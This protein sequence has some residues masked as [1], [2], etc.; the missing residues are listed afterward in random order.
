MI[1]RQTAY[2]FSLTLY[3]DWQRLRPLL[4][5][6]PKLYFHSIFLPKKVTCIG[7]GNKESGIRAE[8]VALDNNKNLLKVEDGFLRSLG[9]GINQSLSVSILI[10]D[11]GIYYDATRPSRLENI[12]NNHQFSSSCLTQAQNVLQTLQTHKL[13]KYNHT[14]EPPSIVFPLKHAVKR[15]LVVDQTKGDAS[16]RDGLGSEK[17]FQCM[18]QAAIQENP[19]TEIW[20]KSHPDV[21]TG[22][23]QGYFDY[24][25]LK[26]SHP[27]LNWL[28]ESWNI[29]SILAYFE[30]VYV[31]T[32]QLGFDALIAG[33]AVTCF[34]VPFYAGWGLTDD[35]QP[36]QRRLRKRTL[37]E[38][39]AAAY[40]EYALYLNPETG[41]QGDFFQAAQFIIRQ[42]YYAH[43]WHNNGVFMQTQDVKTMWSGRIFCFGFRYWKHAHVRPFFGEG[44]K[45]L[46]VNSVTE[47][48]SHGISSLD[49]IA[50]WGQKAIYGLESLAQN[51]QLPITRVEDGFLRSVGLGADFVRPKSLVFDQSG[52]YFDPSTPSD[53]ENILN[54]SVFDESLLQRAHNIRETVCRERLTKY[55]IDYQP[56]AIELP[57]NQKI[58]L[59]PGQVEDDASI[60]KGAAAIKTNLDLLKAA[61]HA[62][63]KAFIIYKPHPDVLARNRQGHVETELLKSLCDHIESQASVID[64][65]EKC[66]EIHTITSLTG[67]DALLRNKRV[68]TY[69][70]PFYAGWG[71]TEDHVE[72][73][74]RQRQLQLDELVAGALILYPRY[75]DAKANGFVECETIIER[76][77]TERAKKQQQRSLLPKSWQRQI[78]KWSSFLQGS[79]EGWLVRRQAKS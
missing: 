57:L 26:Q 73:P 28:T 10:D 25:Q 60:L 11:I 61:R 34:G 5:C 49:R 20:I 65:I 44:A 56:I 14:P 38:L 47:A 54:T 69:G 55:N 78:R 46:F 30:K 63:P 79:W 58:I 7:W 36:C 51:L 2:V 23:K 72:L 13:S 6:R 64:C 77:V 43:Y 45:L 53:L 74:R 40:L 27:E 19:Q 41:Q 1:D 52:I 29:H 3:H 22:K 62:N 59:V 76:L 21:L 31:V 71:L 33:K 48:K 67:F 37:L 39:I 32:S 18:L 24:Q 16:V 15:I 8:Q 9:L 35:R 17:H 4:S 75:W 50:V 66:D 42:R 12:L 70:S 68:I